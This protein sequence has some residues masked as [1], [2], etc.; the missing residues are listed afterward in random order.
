MCAIK[1]GIASLKLKVFSPFPFLFFSN[2][3]AEIGEELQPLL[4]L[5]TAKREGGV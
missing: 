1:K 3:N 4:S 2:R 5:E